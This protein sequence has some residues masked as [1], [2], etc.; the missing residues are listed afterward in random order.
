[1]VTPAVA[2]CRPIGRKTGQRPA[3]SNR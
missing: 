2:A 3:A 1:M